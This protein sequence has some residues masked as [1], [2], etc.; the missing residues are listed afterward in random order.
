MRI[1]S[2]FYAKLSAIFLVLMLG[3]GLALAALCIQAAMRY[4]DEATQKLNRT[5]ASDLAP[6]FEPFLVDSVHHAAIEGVIEEMTGINR[7]IDIYLLDGRGAV[8]AHLMGV[9]AQPLERK[10]VA[11]QP[12]R[13]FIGGAPLPILGDDPLHAGREK[14]FS[15]APTEAMGETDCY[16]YVILESEQYASAAAMIENSYILRATL[17]GLALVLLFTGLAGLGLFAL[18]TRRLRQRKEAIEAFEQGHYDRRVPVESSDEIGQLGAAFNRM[19]DTI[20]QSMDELRQVSRMR[21]ELIANVSHDLRSPIASIQGYLE[22]I[23]I[24]NGTLA[25]EERERYVQIGLR[26][27]RRLS[28]L[29]DELFELSKLDARPIEPQREPFSVAELAQDVV[30]QFAPRAEEAGIRLQAERAAPGLPRAC[31]DIALTERAL[32]NLIDNALRYTPAGGAVR[33]ALDAARLPDGGPAV[34]VTVRDTGRG[35]PAEDLPHVFER[36]YRVEKSRGRSGAGGTGLG[37]A[38]AKKVVEVQGG[39]LK[40]QSEVGRGTTLAF[41][42]PAQA[43]VSAPAV[44]APAA[45]A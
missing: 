19:A 28:A 21:R 30:M 13:R 18:L 11:L 43:A 3:L 7:R 23:L 25:P 17:S 26:N 4:A 45:S 42:L 40:A 1:L 15:V 41:T 32:S 16:L 22:T 36:F 2:S 24:K 35:I 29:V 38:I 31:A 8:K 12:I 14:P 33:V 27:A 20:T 34:R 39:T 9:G 5:L 44:S 6:R 37:L 10:R